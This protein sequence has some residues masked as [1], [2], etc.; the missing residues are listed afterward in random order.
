MLVK[1]KSD[2]DKINVANFNN[3]EILNFTI[4]VMRCEIRHVMPFIK[5]YNLIPQIVVIK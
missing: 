2:P 1:K 3:S 4:F 5:S